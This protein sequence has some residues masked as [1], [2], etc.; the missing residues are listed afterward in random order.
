M[1]AEELVRAPGT[2]PLLEDDDGAVRP[3]A[4]SLR[5]AGLVRLAGPS[6]HHAVAFDRALGR[7][8]QRANEDHA[9]DGR[10]HHDRSRHESTVSPP[11]PA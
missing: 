4:R 1:D 9:D 8:G 5:L 6:G 10:D 3:H 11:R 7:G 2:A